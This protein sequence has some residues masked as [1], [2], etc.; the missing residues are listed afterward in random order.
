MSRLP[1]SAASRTRWATVTACALGVLYMGT[2]LLTPLY[3]LYRQAFGIT[4]LA[5]TEIYA[6]YVIGNLGVLFFF[7][8]LSDDIG[9][10]RVALLALGATLAATLLFLAA[11]SVGWLLAARIVSG[12]AAGLG[13]G[14]LTAWIGELMPGGDE[15][16]AALASAANLAGLTW[17]ALIGG[18]VAGHAPW[19]LRSGFVVYALLLIAT[20][21]M[22]WRAPDT[23]AHPRTSWRSISLRPRIGIPRGIRLPF[24]GAAA[25][26]FAA[27]ALGGFY[28]AL[29]P[30]LLTGPL[31]VDDLTIIGAI[32]ALFFGTAA[33]TAYL[34]RRLGSRGSVVGA[35][36]LLLVGVPLLL[37]A[38][39]WRSMAALVVATIANGAAIALGYR[40]SLVIVTEI[41]PGDRRAEVVSSYLL[42]CYVANAL[43][44]L[45][46]G[47]LTEAVGA[48]FAHRVLGGVIAALAGIAAVVALR[49]GASHAKSTR[50]PAKPRRTGLRQRATA[51]R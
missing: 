28:A 9:R 40:G 46:I 13:A 1:S 10:R 17:G 51:R 2:T 29:A 4:A 16:S 39:A 48:A 22:L 36:A 18:G 42:V 21:A 7:G 27:F 20:M 30:G 14:A 45:G 12:F 25:I 37:V 35:L 23:L 49:Y 34:T 38:E 24:L 11:T 3:P 31:G 15:K 41:A 44:V 32:V 33:I 6:A 43:P 47:W 5:V 19:P 50:F 26:A 8:R